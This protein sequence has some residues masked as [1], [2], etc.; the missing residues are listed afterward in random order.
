MKKLKLSFDGRNNNETW[1][2][3]QLTDVGEPH[4]TLSRAKP[5]T[6]VITVNFESALEKQ[7]FYAGIGLCRARIITPK[8]SARVVYLTAFG[9]QNENRIDL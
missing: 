3:D 6:D 1:C 9:V 5:S 7:R 4:L 8:P 2:I